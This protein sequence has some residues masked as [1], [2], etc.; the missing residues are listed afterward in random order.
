MPKINSQDERMKESR[1]KIVN[2][3]IAM[4]MEFI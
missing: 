3:L 4:E 1:K 2:Y